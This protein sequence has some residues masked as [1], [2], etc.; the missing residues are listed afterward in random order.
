MPQHLT[1]FRNIDTFGRFCKLLID[2]IGWVLWRPAIL[3]PRSL[4]ASAGVGD[5]RVGWS[6]AFSRGVLNGIGSAWYN[7]SQ[8]ASPM[9]R[10]SDD[11]G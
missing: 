6:P 5:R 3:D 4:V 9:C 7:V 11:R 10:K 2:R 1:I 8:R